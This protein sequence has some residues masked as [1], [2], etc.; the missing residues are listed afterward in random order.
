MS[1]G[2][3]FL[4]S[5]KEGLVERF[6][7]AFLLVLP[8]IPPIRSQSSFRICLWQPDGLALGNLAKD[9]YGVLPADDHHAFLLEWI[10][11]RWLCW[12]AFCHVRIVYHGKDCGCAVPLDSLPRI[13]FVS[14][15]KKQEMPSFEEG[16][17][18]LYHMTIVDGEISIDKWRGDNEEK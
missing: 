1:L 4:S 9:F 14:R 2:T 10:E 5:P 15:A 8:S 11:V 3:F 13:G 17:D 12:S 7:L 18:E 16:F 6:I